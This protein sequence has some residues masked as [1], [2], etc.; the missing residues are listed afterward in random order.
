LRNLA[1]VMALRRPAW[2]NLGI[3]F[4]SMCGK[5]GSVGGIRGFRMFNLT[6]RLLILAPRWLWERR[7][8]SPRV[9]YRAAF[10]KCCS[11]G[12]GSGSRLIML[13][14]GLGNLA[15]GMAVEVELLAPMCRFWLSGREIWLSTK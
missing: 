14:Q 15:L 5:S 11:E 10:E 7:Q 6:L 3:D 9:D 4:D 12:S 2:L 1:Q 8:R 13:A